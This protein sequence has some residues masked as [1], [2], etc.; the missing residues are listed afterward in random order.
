MNGLVDT[1]SACRLADWA[2]ASCLVPLPKD[3]PGL[4]SQVLT[5][6]VRALPRGRS[7]GRSF[8]DRP[9]YL[10]PFPVCHLASQFERRLWIS[11]VLLPACDFE[12]DIPRT[13]TQT[14]NRLEFLPVCLINFSQ[15]SVQS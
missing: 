1:G 5:A 2:L 11:L 13:S 6:S 7:A 8:P 10:V 3:G 4:S 9:G 15:G 14:S 12:L